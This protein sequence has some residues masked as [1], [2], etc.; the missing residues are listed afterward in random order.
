MKRN[1]RGSYRA[2]MRTETGGLMSAIFVWGFLAL[3]M[4][5]LRQDPGY[6]VVVRSANEDA[7]PEDQ[8][9][10]IYHDSQD[11]QCRLEHYRHQGEDAAKGI[12]AYKDERDSSNRPEEVDINVVPQHTSSKQSSR[13]DCHEDTR[14]VQ[15]LALRMPYREYQT[16]LHATH[17]TGYR[18]DHGERT[19]DRPVLLMSVSLS[20]SPRYCEFVKS[21]FRSNSTEST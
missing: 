12:N 13:S 1:S 8:L 17:E 7:N 5:C 16:C 19:Q 4:V 20:F 10:A 9:C 14:P 6:E 18:D 3:P 11:I 2:I 15:A 21:P